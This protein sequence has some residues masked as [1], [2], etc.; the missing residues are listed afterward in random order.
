MTL[1]DTILAINKKIKGYGYDSLCL[2]YKIAREAQARY[3][4]GNIFNG[5]LER[6]MKAAQRDEIKF[7]EILDDLIGEHD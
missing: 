3:E 4:A 7:F 1:N 5:D 6:S 2:R